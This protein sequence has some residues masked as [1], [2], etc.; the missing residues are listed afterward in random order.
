MTPQRLKRTIATVVF[1]S[2][3][4]V[5]HY[6]L[7]YESKMVGSIVAAVAP[8]IYFRFAD[9]DRPTVKMKIRCRSS[10][11]VRFTVTVTPTDGDKI[12]QKFVLLSYIPSMCA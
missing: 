3:H 1:S 8:K 5:K 7:T 10:S 11:S 9:N 12:K 4:K 6:Y 2:R